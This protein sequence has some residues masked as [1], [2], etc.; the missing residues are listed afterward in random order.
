MFRGTGPHCA[1]QSRKCAR[2]RE[3]RAACRVLSSHFLI[4][5]KTNVMQNNRGRFGRIRFACEHGVRANPDDNHRPRQHGA[6][7]ASHLRSRVTG[8]RSKVVGLNVYNDNNQ[9]VGSINDLLMDKSGNIKAAVLSVG[10]FLGVGSQLVAIPFDK[11][12]FVNEPVAYTGVS[13]AP[14]ARATGRATTTT[15]GSATTS[16]STTTHVEAQSLVS[17]PRASSTPPRMSSSRC[18]SS[19]IRSNA[20]ADRSPKEKRARFCRARFALGDLRLSAPISR[21]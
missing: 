18:R 19:N 6:S 3:R 9:N 10:G 2:A 21:C 7:G 5:E 20:A 17:G 1:L 13:N 11:I 8:G 12:K 14:N 15:T 4:R 16:S